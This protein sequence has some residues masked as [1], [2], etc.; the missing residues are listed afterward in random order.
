M[1]L[2][3]LFGKAQH[4]KEQSRAKNGAAQAEHQLLRERIGDRFRGNGERHE[5]S[6]KPNEN[7]KRDSLVFGF[8]GFLRFE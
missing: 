4:E 3:F 6:C 8:H 7:S 1:G 2:S 5:H